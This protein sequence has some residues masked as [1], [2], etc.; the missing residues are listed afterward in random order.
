MR[1]GIYITLFLA[2][3][4]GVLLL[5]GPALGATALTCTPTAPDMLGPFY[6]PNAPMRASVGSG[7]I[8]KGIVQSVDCSPVPGAKIELWLAGPN[9]QYDD[10]H[11]ATIMSDSAGFYR[12][13]SNVPN[14]YT[15][16]P[17]HIHL[18]VTAD[19]FKELVTQHY[20]EA[21]KTEATFNLVIVPSK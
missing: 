6:A 4:G 12:F 14:P 2:I 15:G 16:R 21:G 5:G 17:P 20:P 3:A 7:Y 1:Y 18:R 19:G 8:L 11:R 10:A 13:E 9:G